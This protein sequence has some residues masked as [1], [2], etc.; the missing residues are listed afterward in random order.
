MAIPMQ[1]FDADTLVML[2][3]CDY[4]A[5]LKKFCVKKNDFARFTFIQKFEIYSYVEFWG[6]SNGTNH[7]KRSSLVVSLVDFFEYA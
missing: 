3:R 1:N 2:K 4:D 5:Y 6:G 7:L